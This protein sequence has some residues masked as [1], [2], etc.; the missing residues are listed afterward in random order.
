MLDGMAMPP[1]LARVI[2]ASAQTDQQAIL[3]ECE[4]MEKVVSHLFDEALDDS[5]MP[6]ELIVALRRQRDEIRLAMERLHT[7]ERPVTMGPFHA[8]VQV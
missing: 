1:A 2:A 4:H 7:L 3:Q 8:V 6:F 5:N